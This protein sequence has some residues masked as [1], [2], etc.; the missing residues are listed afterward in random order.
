MKRMWKSSLA[1]VILASGLMGASVPAS[2]DTVSMVCTSGPQQKFCDW[3]VKEFHDRT[4]HDV[5][6]V[7]MSNKANEVL[8]LTQ[9][10]L[11]A[12][13]DD[14]DVIQMTVIHPG[15]LRPFLE[16]LTPYLPADYKENFFPGA[17]DNYTVDGTQ[18]GIPIFM[19]VGVMLYRQDLLE[20]Y[21]LSYPETWEELTAAAKTIQEG[22][23]AAGNN[24][25]W[26]YVWQ[27]KSYAGLQCNAH[28]WFDSVGGGKTLE[29]NGEIS[30]NNQANIDMLNLASS[31]VG[32]ISPPGVL[33]YAEGDSMALFRVGDAA[34]LRYWPGGYKAANGAKSA[35]SGNAGLGLLP[36]GDGP[37]SDHV[38]TLGGWGWGINKA[39]VNKEL[40]AELLMFLTSEEA[41]LKYYELRGSPPAR[42]DATASI[43][44]LGIFADA[45]EHASPRTVGIAGERYNQVARVTWESVHS[46]LSGKVSA[47][48]AIASLEAKLTDI[49]GSGW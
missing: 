22:E 47:S 14:V 37:G 36:K 18:I 43:E 39:S 21:G 26:G 15:A 46:A 41:Q 31:W 19:A 27:G 8:S 24:K 11:A 16:D 28:E 2:A 32:E 29:P 30:V 10:L 38:G 42:R 35:I 6:L 12:G 33:S 5:E 13:A 1:S 49:K 44:E 23:R 45:F 7:E 9:Q 25:F 20:K 48:E 17:W 40:A 4:G 3:V 34:F